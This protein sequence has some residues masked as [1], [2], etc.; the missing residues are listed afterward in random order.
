MALTLTTTPTP[1]IHMK[2]KLRYGKPVIFEHLGMRSVCLLDDP[3]EEARARP[4]RVT[5]CHA[6]ALLPASLL[7]LPSP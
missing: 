6:V 5:A 1:S 7:A 3:N 2:F 4:H